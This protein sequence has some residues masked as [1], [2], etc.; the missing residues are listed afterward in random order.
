MSKP[1]ILCVDDQREVLAAVKREL[2]PFS[3]EYEI[4]ECESASE[5]DEVLSDLKNENQNLALI[6]CDHI[7][8]GENGVDFLAKIDASD[9]FP[10]TKKV[11]LTGLAS[12][13]DTIKA[14]NEA[15]IDHY[16]EKPWDSDNF[17]SVI[18][19]LLA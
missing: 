10:N 5:A 7:M 3:A 9:N 12:H 4:V 8:P 14:I 18:K 15:H 11:L 19:K 1:N 2:T 17:V 6:I 13:Q 16:F